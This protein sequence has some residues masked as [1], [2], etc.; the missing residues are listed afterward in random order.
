MSKIYITNEGVSFR[1]VPDKSAPQT[2]DCKGCL[3]DVD[4]EGKL[5]N[6]NQRVDGDDQCFREDLHYEEVKVYETLD[7][8][9]FEK[10]PDQE[11]LEACE[12]CFFHSNGSVP[13]ILSNEVSEEVLLE[14]D[15]CVGEDYYLKEVKGG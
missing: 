2:E 5:C 11:E 15:G 12:R 6:L 14:V 4:G 7:G 9:R 8:D 13:C 10:V 3:F 1:A